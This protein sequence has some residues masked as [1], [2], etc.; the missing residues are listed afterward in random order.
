MGSN[1]FGVIVLPRRICL[2]IITWIKGGEGG[3]CHIALR[4]DTVNHS[5]L[6]KRPFLSNPYEKIDC[7]KT[8]SSICG[9]LLFV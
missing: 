1:S 9:V 6:K 3:I 4:E 5:E 2:A 7:G 8:M